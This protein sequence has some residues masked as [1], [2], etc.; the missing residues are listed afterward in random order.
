MTTEFSDAAEALTRRNWRILHT[1]AR[2][3][4]GVRVAQAQVAVSAI[5]QRL[6]VEF[7]DTNRDTGVAVLPVW[8]SPWGGQSAFLP[9]LRSL[10]VVT[11]LLL[12]LVTANVGN[13]LL[14]RATARQQEITVRLALGAGRVRLVRQLLT[15]SVLLAGLGG[16]LGCVFA[17]W[18]VG[19][20]FK[21]LPPLPH[22]PVAYDMQ[23]NG[24][25]LLF[26]AI[27]TVVTGLLFGLAP[28]L[29]AVRTNLD[30]ALKQAGRTGAPGSRS[31]RLRSALVV[32]EVALALILLVG[33]TLCAQSL[34]R[35]RQLDL[36]LDP[37]NVWAVG[38]RL[39]LV[40]YDD[41][42]T[43]H[44]YHRLREELAAL[45]GVESVALADWL[46]L[47][48]EGGG[49]TRFAVAGYQ[50][51]PG[52][53][54]SA[55]VSTV[56]PDYFRALRI[57]LLAGREF[58][59]RDNPKAPRAVVINQLFADRYCAG[60]N[61]LGLKL[62]FWSYEWT[63]V[64]VARNGKYRSL[65]EPPQPFIYVCEPQVSHRNLAAIVRTT[66]DPHG[67]ARTVERTAV[68]VDPL[69]KPIAA[70]SMMDY[71][72]GAFTIP[73][74]AATLLT[75]LGLVALL[76]AALGIYGVMAYSV[77]QRT[78]EIGLRMALGAQRL[79]VLRLFLMQG[80]KL[81]ALGVVVGGI[82]T[83]A[84]AQVLS[85]LL[86]GVSVNDPL[87]YVS[88]IL[89]MAAAALLACWWPA[90]RATKIAP[91]EALRYE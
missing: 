13:L 39:P 88:V 10:A 25:V 38:F 22:L 33:M 87:I 79:D 26:S 72:A 44:T 27:V 31:H 18:G 41:E 2:L 36:G 9:L 45:P 91:M 30:A 4:P 5:M 46:P 74:M 49:S 76:L 29:Q 23:L 84:A 70:L 71:T 48:L 61:P 47:G 82:G 35:A 81:T 73:R 24:K 75:A 90:R 58:A 3:Q 83:V 19:L 89:L 40:G 43:R 64:G 86:I 15:E 14:A 11:L 8:K 50:P 59:E 67:I 52:E 63:V 85:T 65:N 37:R 7:A 55:G 32:A 51:A 54:M 77:G 53:A 69:L 68:A 62:D 6:A 21:L 1:Y 20:I 42:R 56:S 80:M 60:H 78:R 12:L 57:P 16:I 28:A 17:A 66:S 34:R